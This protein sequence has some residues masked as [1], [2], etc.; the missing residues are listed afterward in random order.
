MNMKGLVVAISGILTIVYLGAIF[1]ASQRTLA[2]RRWAIANE[3]EHAHAV[4][5]SEGEAFKAGSKT[6]GVLLGQNKKLS[7]KLSAL[8][9]QQNP[10]VTDLQVASQGFNML[11]VFV[12][13]VRISHNLGIPFD[14]LKT[15]AQTS[16]SLSK[17][18]H[19]LKPDSDVKA[20]VRE[21][22][23]QAVDDLEESYWAIAQSSSISM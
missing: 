12:V 7:D 21:A 19:V 15:Q 3:E 13:A 16:G 11:A 14:Q 20:E 22:A 10:P 5:R 4:S 6:P 8:L 23:R 9:R 17:A 18:I 1:E 2:Q